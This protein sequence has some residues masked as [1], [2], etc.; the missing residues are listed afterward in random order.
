LLKIGIFNQL[1]SVQLLAE[2]FLKTAKSLLSHLRDTVSSKALVNVLRPIWTSK[3]V[4]QKT[5]QMLIKDVESNP[6]ICVNFLKEVYLSGET[7]VAYNL[8]DM[9]CKSLLQNPVNNM[10]KFIEMI[11]SL[12]PLL[13]KIDGC[14]QLSSVHHLAGLFLNATKKSKITFTWHMPQA[15]FPRDKTIEEFFRGPLQVMRFR[16][17]GWRGIREAREFSSIIS[18]NNYSS[19]RSSNSG[20]NKSKNSSSSTYTVTATADGA[21]KNAHIIITKT[22]GDF[23]R[24]QA[25]L[26]K[27][28]QVRNTIIN[29]MGGK[30]PNEASALTRAADL[31]NNNVSK[32]PRTDVILLN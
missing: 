18:G 6:S 9:I 1:P 8:I 13:L 27:V 23:E 28:I 17:P 30:R 19:H 21:G 31:N 3:D 25:E 22:R 26:D 10:Q 16:N 12:L 24:R 11:S 15:N 20:Y 7:S 4:F 5:A 2:L 14:N 32:K 29:L